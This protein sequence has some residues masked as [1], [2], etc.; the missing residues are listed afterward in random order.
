M[1][2]NYGCS[3]S[4]NVHTLYLPQQ[5]L[6]QHKLRNCLLTWFGSITGYLVRGAGDP[7][8]MRTER[9]H[10]LVLPNLVHLRQSA[11]GHAHLQSHHVPEVMMQ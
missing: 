3:G 6:V 8:A 1:G 4:A 5:K 11:K 7:V 10:V 9:G 2:C